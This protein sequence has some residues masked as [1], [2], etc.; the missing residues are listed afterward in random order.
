MKVKNFNCTNDKFGTKVPRPD[1]PKE[2]EFTFSGK[3]CAKSKKDCVYCGKGE[4]FSEKVKFRTT[5]NKKRYT[6]PNVNVRTCNKCKEHY[7]SSETYK[8]VIDSIKKLGGK[9]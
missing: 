1:E 8:M 9:M 6:V 3:I 4:L 5:I 7:M 2:V